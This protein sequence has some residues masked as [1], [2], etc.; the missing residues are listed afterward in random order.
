MDISVVVPVYNTENYLRKCVDS[1]INQQNVSIEIILVDDCS[2]KQETIQTLKDYA[3]KYKFIKIVKHEKN[4][5]TLRGRLTGFKYASGEYIAYL[6]SDDTMSRDYLRTLRKT[7]TDKKA[8]VVV[9]TFLIDNADTKLK[10]QMLRCPFLNKNFDLKGEEI[11]EMFMKQEGKYYGWTLVWNKLYHRSVI[12][13]FYNELLLFSKANVGLNMLEDIAFSLFVYLN[14]NHLVS[15][16]G[17][18]VYYY[19]H[20]N[21]FTNN[22][23]NMNI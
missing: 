18:Y 19:K 16:S 6:D 23:E 9:S 12:Q 14:A 22:N 20:Q 13:K 5:G 8:D 1:I 10:Y 4:Y 7:A 2:T 15:V 17:E 3:R 21:A 11:F